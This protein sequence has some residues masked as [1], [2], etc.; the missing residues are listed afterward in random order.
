MRLLINYTLEWTIGHCFAESIKFVFE[1][2][3]IE[4]D[5]EHNCYNSKLEI[6][7]IGLLIALFLEIMLKRWVVIS[8]KDKYINFQEEMSK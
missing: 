7:I 1:S 5:Q 4:K 6:K 8:D 2:F 3:Q